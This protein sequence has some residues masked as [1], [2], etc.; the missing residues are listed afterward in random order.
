[1]L[2]V[3]QDQ[4]SELDAGPRKAGSGSERFC[5]LTRQVKPVAEMIRFVVGPDGTAV[6]DLKRNLPGR[7]LWITATREAVKEAV[8]RQILPKAFKRDVRIPGDF[9]AATEQLIERS[10][11]DALAIAGKAGQVVTGFSKVE[12]ALVR[13]RV[14]GLVHASDGS[15]EGIR[16][17]A[18]AVRS[19]GLENAEKIPVILAFSSTQLDLALGR[20][21][22]VH[23]ALLAGPASD[24]FIA[25]CARL[26][27]FRTGNPGGLKNEGARHRDARRLGTE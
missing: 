4:D 21:N 22:V 8:K 16:K 17:I 6:P 18:A 23:A 13:G 11:L 27:R 14:I 20:P 12:A 19:L 26:E 7:G 24:T 2:V 10:A 1:M 3:N 9:V 5:A 25:R 15:P